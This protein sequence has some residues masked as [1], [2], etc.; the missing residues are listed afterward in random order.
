MGKYCGVMQSVRVGSGTQSGK[1]LLGVAI[2]HSFRRPYELINELI[3]FGSVMPI[4]AFG[5]IW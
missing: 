2:M 1:A 5:L 3:F 4:A